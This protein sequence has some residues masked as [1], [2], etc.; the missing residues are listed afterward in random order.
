MGLIIIAGHSHTFA[1]VGGGDDTPTPHL[2]PVD[3]YDNVFALHSRW[4]RPGDY[5]STLIGHAAGNAV[6]LVWAGNTH[7]V[8]FLLEQ[9]PPID[10]ICRQLPDLPLQEG[11]VVVPES[12]IRA[13]FL[14]DNLELPHVLEAL[15]AQVNSRIAVVAT[16]PPNPDND[17]LMSLLADELQF[18]IKPPGFSEERLKLTSPVIRL[19]LWRLLQDL[20]EDEA[21]KAGVEFIPVPD[22]VTDADG[23]LKPEFWAGDVTH[24]NSAYGQVMLAHVAATLGT[25][26]EAW[27]AEMGH[28]AMRIRSQ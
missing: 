27:R 4:P 17:H 3:G 18:M 14:S 23:F 24:A 25:P 2:L 13:K 9:N 16:P 26:G 5:W 6:A 1:L 22:T 12:L 8:L 11:A 21:T 15:K 10:F 19:K 20:Y 28:G 7:N